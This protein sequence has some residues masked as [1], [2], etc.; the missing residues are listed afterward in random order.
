MKLTIYQLRS[1]NSFLDGLGANFSLSVGA[2][3][4]ANTDHKSYDIVRACRFIFAAIM[5]ENSILSF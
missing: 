1:L 3:P 2:G 5:N 4:L